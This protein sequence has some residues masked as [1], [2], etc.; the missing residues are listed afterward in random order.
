M[1]PW[2]AHAL[3][4]SFWRAPGSPA[5]CTLGVPLQTQRCWGKAA[6]SLGRRLRISWGLEPSYSCRCFL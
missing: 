4:E 3:G 6:E 5:A 2:R 1:G